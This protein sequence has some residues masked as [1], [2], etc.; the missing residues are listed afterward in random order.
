VE[1]NNSRLG[2]IH[3][4][5][6]EEAEVLEVKTSGTNSLEELQEV[7]EGRQE[8]LSRTY[9]I[10]STTSS[11]EAGKEAADREAIIRQHRKAKTSL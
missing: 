4:E 9:L 7:E 1:T 8:I 6:L 5:A 10:T 11:Q 3:S 2:E